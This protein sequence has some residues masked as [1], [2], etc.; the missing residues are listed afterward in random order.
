VGQAD[1]AIKQAELALASA[2]NNLT[3][4]QAAYDDAVAKAE[5]RTVTSSISG[6]V[7]AV[8]IEPGKSLGAVAGTA[9]VAPVQIADLSRMVVSVE[10][11]EI[12]ILKVQAE[13]TARMTF[14]AVPNL[15]ISGKVTHISTVSSG[16]ADVANMSMGAGG[17]GG[18]VTY[19][20]KI[21]IENPD[22]RL[23]P[24][25]TAKATI[26]FKSLDDVLL[27][28]MSAVV[29]LS[30]TE[31]LVSLVDPKDSQKSTEKNVKILASDGLMVAVEGDLKE[32]DEVLSVGGDGQGLEGGMMS[33]GSGGFAFG[34]AIVG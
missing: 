5:K 11:N 33:S 14:S 34:T 24:G 23:K 2:R 9:P 29:M 4:A 22:P 1:S 3:N 32:G 28:P 21:L 12:D 30:D 13:Q 10:V 8:N 27:V 26:E 19:S 6:S 15:E 20:V 7:V 25:M 18:M 16:G 17:M 31:G